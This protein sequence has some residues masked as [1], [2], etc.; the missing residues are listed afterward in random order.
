MKSKKDWIV[1]QACRLFLSKGYDGVSVQDICTSVGMTKGALYHHFLNKDDLFRAVV[2]QY[3]GIKA[4]HL[5]KPF[6]SLRNYVDFK[7]EKAKVLVGTAS[8]IQYVPMSYLSLMLDAMRHYP[9]IRDHKEQILNTEF[10][11]AKRAL[12]M[13]VQSGEIR[14]DINVEAT[15]LNFISITLGIAACLIRTNSYE[16]SVSNYETQ[17]NELY[18]LL[19]K[20]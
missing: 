3:S 18:K 1:E 2:E 20:Q 5:E 10:T 4:M 13:A 8:D 15:A 11:E 17:L 6:T 9:E 16:I 14:D 7:V 19:V 12:E